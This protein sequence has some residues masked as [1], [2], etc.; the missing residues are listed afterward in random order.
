MLR[1]PTGHENPDHYRFCGGCGAALHVNA[2]PG[3]VTQPPPPMP[4]PPAGPHGVRT[5]YPGGGIV[6]NVGFAKSRISPWIWVGAAVIACVAALVVGIMIFK[7]SSVDYA[8]SD[9][10]RAVAEDTAASSSRGE[11]DHVTGTADDWLGAVC[12]PGSYHDGGGI[13][14]FTMVLARGTCRSKVGNTDLTVV[15]QHGQG[16]WDTKQ[17]GAYA[18]GPVDSQGL[19]GVIVA[20]QSGVGH[21]DPLE[22]LRQYGFVL[23][24]ERG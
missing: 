21:S 9:V 4:Y 5:G 19:M 10:G 16:K 22:A 7:S 2:P 11:Y 12:N 1:C 13:D 8:A 23:Y 17:M 20:E 15:V 24:G 6:S 3:N 14:A 18:T